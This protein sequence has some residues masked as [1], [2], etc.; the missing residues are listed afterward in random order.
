MY[1]GKN[2]TH[3]QQIGHGHCEWFLGIANKHDG[4]V[5]QIDVVGEPSQWFEC[6]PAKEPVNPTLKPNSIFITA[7]AFY[8]IETWL[9]RT[10]SLQ[11]FVLK[12]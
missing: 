11:V 6:F 8:V 5:D 10:Q 7:L 12:F 1:A 4:A 2:N 9:E 3:E